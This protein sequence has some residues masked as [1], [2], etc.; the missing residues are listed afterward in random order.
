MINP[1]DYRPSLVINDKNETDRNKKTNWRKIELNYQAKGGE[2]YLTLGNF[3]QQAT[4]FWGKHSQGNNPQ[5]DLIYLLDN[6]EMT[7]MDPAGGIACAN[8]GKNKRL[9]YATNHRHTNKKGIIEELKIEGIAKVQ[10]VLENQDART[11]RKQTQSSG[12]I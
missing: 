9:L 7:A 11:A 6:V 12:E 8:Y 10:K 3:S 2:Q 4:L 5:G 1:L